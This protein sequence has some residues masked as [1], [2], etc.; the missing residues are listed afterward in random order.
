MTFWLCWAVVPSGCGGDNKGSPNDCTNPATCPPDVGCAPG[1]VRCGPD[2]AVQRCRDDGSG[3]DTLAHCEASQ[4]CSGGQCSPA[5]CMGAT[6]S[7]TADGRL[8]TCLP[9]IGQFGDPQACPVGQICFGTG[10]IPQVCPPSQRF[11][12]DPQTVSQ[13]DPLGGGSQV[14][15]RCDGNSACANGGCVDACQAADINKSFAGCRF[16]SVDMDNAATDDTLENDLAV[17][18]QSTF[19]ANVKIEVRNGATWTMLCQA[20]V[21]P[22]QTHVFGLTPTCAPSDT[23]HYD[24][25]IEDSGLVNAAAYRISS[26][27]P[28]VAYQ[29]NSN[30]MNGAANSSGA[31][32]LLPRST[33]GKKYYALDWPQPDPGMVIDPGDASR[34]S[35]DIVA[36]EDGTE[37]TVRSSTH[38]IAGGAVPMMMPGDTHTF[39]LN[40]GDVLQLETL[41]T[42]DDLSGTYIESTRPVAVFAG[43]ECAIN[44][45]PRPD[46]TGGDYCDHIE[47]QLLPL[48]A[49]G[50][51]YVAAR[52]V[53][54]PDSD[55]CDASGPA[56]TACPP[57]RWRVLGSVDG[58]VVTL[59]PP[60]GTTLTP[61]GPLTLH[62]GEVQDVLA[63]GSSVTSPGDFLITATQPILVM[64]LSGGEATMTTTVPVE[65][66]LPSYLFE[67]TDY[68]C[69]NLTVVRK[70]GASV[71]L[72]NQTIADSLFN[73]VAGDYEVARLP[74]NMTAC[75]VGMGNGNV[76]PHQVTSIAGPENRAS[77]AGILVN[78]LD[79]ICSYAYVGGLAITVI[80]PVE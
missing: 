67:V 7:C 74:L 11:C 4:S 72:D 3:W 28:I 20:A 55:G 1:S 5:G 73:P 25:H 27:A 8:E 51:N 77:P 39:D 48:Q 6:T 68:F 44:P 59:T 12:A 52:V 40:E 53:P 15:Q 69:T 38:I 24:R 49:W 46:G 22:Q 64:Q 58:T 29:Y 61:A 79:D 32:V 34:A 71:Q 36:A 2:R 16:Y 78:G 42:G 60:A 9:T 31:T 76:T 56:E 19:T 14:V 21:P 75:G 66:Y 18:N 54:Q 37:V 17:A 43:V 30:D 35:V 47:E 41:S 50:K 45:D 23:D 33:L 62:A 65:Q 63:M 10:C 57:S 13:C 70:R 80:N 26:D